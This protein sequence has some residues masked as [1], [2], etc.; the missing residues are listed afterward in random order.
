[1]LSNR[2][3]RRRT[4]E[5]NVVEGVLLGAKR[6][7][8]KGVRGVRGNS[9]FARWAATLRRGFLVNLGLPGSRQQ[10]EMER[11]LVLSLLLN[12]QNLE[13]L[14]EPQIESIATNCHGRLYFLYEEGWRL[15]VELRGLLN[16]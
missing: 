5:F 3:C 6:E 13:C 11:A 14:L 10:L 8:R 15:W 4:R 16:A 12:G 9:V 7:K 1:M 2:R